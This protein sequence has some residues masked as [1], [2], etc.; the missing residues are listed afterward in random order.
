MTLYDLAKSDLDRLTGTQTELT[1][2]RKK[3]EYSERYKRNARIAEMR[4]HGMTHQQIADAV[5][6]TKQAV[7]AVLSERAT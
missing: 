6:L 5:G 2:A 7:S 1:M 4:L 3:R